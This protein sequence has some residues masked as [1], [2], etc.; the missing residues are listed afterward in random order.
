[1]TTLRARFAAWTA[2]LLFVSLVAF[3]GLV[4]A[5][6]SRGL[7]ASVDDGLELNASQ[8]LTVIEVE[9][10][11]MD[12]PQDFETVSSELSTPGGVVRI[13]DPD[14]DVLRAFGPYV[15][16][17]VPDDSL[18]M[19][20]NGEAGFLT[21]ADPENG[22]SVRL[23][24]APIE[25][26]GRVIGIYQVGQTL[27]AM[28]YTLRRLRIALL[29]S[30][31]ALAALAGLGGYAL[32]SRALAPIDE[33][34][35]TA[36]RI[37]A[38]D[39]SSRLDAP[40]SAD[41][42]GRLAATFN[43]MLDRLERAFWRER[44]F[45]SD[46]SH[47]LRTP[48][49]AIQVI[50]DVTRLKDRKGADYQRAL[51]DLSREVGRLRLLTESLLMLARTESGETEEAKPVDLSRLLVDTAESMRPLAEAKKL[52]LRDEI[53]DGLTVTGSS[54][55]LI[56]LFSNLLDNAIKY[57]E[58]GGI[59][60]VAERTPS[61]TVCVTVN[62][63]GIGIPAEHL[64]RIFDRFYQVEKSRAYEGTGLGLSIVQ[65]IARAH[66]GSVAVRST[67]GEGS[68]FTVL[69]PLSDGKEQA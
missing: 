8:A 6:T 26:E 48:L 50:L 31:P 47:E 54:D 41:E 18:E 30:A 44:Q 57:T 29:V 2:G 60:L 55:D 61:G 56:R 43:A 20:G 34:T 46:A 7:L 35:R 9:N 10:G 68:T 15:G 4:Y 58:Q 21:L 37:S 39:L 64:D 45:I 32:A 53:T 38:E 5:S 22:E 49:A 23:Y 62:D 1:M 52:A 69:L 65:N 59:T 12:L 63:T 24:T 14:G 28:Q 19:A 67:P 11:R 40:S 36:G 27:A 25:S 66:E 51:D 3:G 33:M 42:V 16:L 17:M 13:M